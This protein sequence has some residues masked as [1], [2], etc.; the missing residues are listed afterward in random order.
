MARKRYSPVQVIVML[1][2]GEV[3]E[4]TGLTQIEVVKHYGLST[5]GTRCHPNAKSSHNI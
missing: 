3:L 2:E 4:S 1:R 5:T